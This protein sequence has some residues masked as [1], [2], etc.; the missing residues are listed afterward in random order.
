MALAR[1]A[2]AL[3]AMGGL[4]SLFAACASQQ[5][6][7]A[8]IVKDM[9]FAGNDHISERQIEK[10]ILTNETGWWP[11]ATKHYFDPVSWEADLK[12]IVRFYVSRG[13]YQAQVV[14]DEVTPKPRNSV[15]LT[16]HISEGPVTHVGK[17]DIRGLDA[18]SAGDR[19]A[20]LKGLPLETGGTFE[21]EAWDAAKQRIV[22]QLRGRGYAEA[23]VDG[24]A[25]V[26]VQTH[27]ANVTLTVRPGLPYYFGEIQV[28]TGENP[29]V[30]GFLVWEQ[31][32]LA[33]PDGRRFSEEAL[34]EAQRRV[35][36]MGVFAVAKVIEGEPDDT[37]QKIPVKVDVR[38]APFYTLRLGLG[39]RA[40]QVRNEARL[41]GEWT[42]RDFLGG[43]RKLTLHGEAGW[44]FIPSVITYLNGTA[45]TEGARNGPI[46]RLGV[47][48]EQ[49]RLFGRPSLR[50]RATIDAQRTLEQTY[51]DLG[52]R[53]S[54]GVVWQILSRLALFPSYQIEVDYLNGSPINSA[55]TAPLTLGCETT[56][57][58][59]VV[60]LSYL[61]QVL[62]WDRRDQPLEPRNG[63]YF[64]ISVQ[65]GGGP[66]GGQFDY[67]RL[68]PDARGYVSFGDEKQL[69]LSARLRVGNLWTGGNP[70]DSAV[71]T[72]FY[73]GG[74]VSMRGFNE[75]RLSPLL[76]VPAPPGSQGAPTLSLPIGG[77]GLIDGSFETRYSITGSFRLAAFVDVGQVTTGTLSAADFGDVLWAVGGGI[78]YLTVVGPIRVD[79]ARRLPY[80]RLPP[81]YGT[82]ATGAIVQVPSYPV[83]TSCFG[84]GGS[85]PATPVNDGSCVLQISIGEAF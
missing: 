68:L 56:T 69:T 32:R 78:R 9:S 83:N 74:A 41:I 63:T 12:R 61:E 6:R 59:C 51:N 43:L 71:V 2:L 1:G 57:T 65:E 53:L 20:A 10:R 79:V 62:T 81:L 23:A 30:P 54:T 58:S 85:R 82:D 31:V 47:L 21:E 77:N 15:A 76:L 60:W 26:D 14:K 18:L 70:E 7:D 64:S 46:G 16:V 66:L 40:D 5:K 29:R 39:V 42:D 38:E 34:E 84:L 44:A 48:F 50:G 36:G 13:F 80:G 72:R 28:S 35:S 4:A 49:P 3:A 11:F 52:A 8:P 37:T 25:L 19:E 27:L 24:E 73:A 55:A 17:I 33:I 75:R 67:V 45:A 22:K